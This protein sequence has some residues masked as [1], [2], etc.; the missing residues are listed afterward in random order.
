VAFES[1]TSWFQ[2]VE[3]RAPRNVEIT[4]VDDDLIGLPHWPA[5]SVFDVIVI[6]GMNRLR[7]A[8]ASI[9][10]LEKDGAV[11]LD[12]SDQPWSPSNSGE[13]E[14]IN[15]F[16]R[17]GYKRID[18]YGYAPSVIRRHCTSVFFRERCFLLEGAE[19]PQ[20]YD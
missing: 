9:G 20:R 2:R 1:D 6:D 7:C 5:D 13:Y 14:I 4:L 12:D 18:F 15:L 8:E 16:R 10:L 3:R 17:Q 11:I 19:P